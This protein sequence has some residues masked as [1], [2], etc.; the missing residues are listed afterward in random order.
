MFPVNLTKDE[1]EVHYLPPQ[2]NIAE[3]LEEDIKMLAPGPGSSTCQPVIHDVS[4]KAPIPPVDEEQ[5][6]RQPL[7]RLEALML[8]ENRTLTLL[9]VGTKEAST[10]FNAPA[11]Q[12]E[13]SYNVS[14]VGEDD[15]EVILNKVDN[16]PAESLG[17]VEA[18]SVTDRE[19]RKTTGKSGDGQTLR[20]VG[21]NLAGQHSGKASSGTWDGPVGYD[22]NFLTEG[23]KDKYLKDHHIS[24]H[25]VQ[26]ADRV[27]LMSCFNILPEGQML[28]IFFHTDITLTGGSTLQGGVWL[29]VPWY[30]DM[31]ETG[32]GLRDLL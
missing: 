21:K 10:Y 28:N 12:D 30:P 5:F 25:C 27:L 18:A 17:P 1:V 31:P 13:A 9:K 22:R 20:S 6:S 7:G 8:K 4:S 24:V 14:D 3:D 2:G 15:I 32:T 19:V 29:G 23:H 11:S 26:Q 16:T